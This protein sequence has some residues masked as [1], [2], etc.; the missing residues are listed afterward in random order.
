VFA[1][2]GTCG[3]ADT[4]EWGDNVGGNGFVFAF[5]GT[6]GAADT[7]EWGDNVGGN[8]AVGVGEGAVSIAEGAGVVV[9]ANDASESWEGFQQ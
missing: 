7:V 6:C 1:F 3:A 5:M 9:G 8:G 2:M 4:V